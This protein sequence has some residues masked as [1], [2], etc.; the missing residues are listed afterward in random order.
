[1]IRALTAGSG[2]RVKGD[3]SR[4]NA[5]CGGRRSRGVLIYSQRCAVMSGPSRL[6]T[7]CSW[8]CAAD[9]KFGSSSSSMSLSLSFQKKSHKPP[10]YS[11]SVMKHPMRWVLAKPVVTTGLPSTSRSVHIRPGDLACKAT[12]VGWSCGNKRPAHSVELGVGPLMG[13]NFLSQSTQFFGGVI[14]GGALDELR[15]ITWPMQMMR[16]SP[17]Q[18]SMQAGKFAF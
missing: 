13:T 3:A 11:T 10:V 14:E 4:I 17:S 2:I 8:L 12:T 15:V 9:L 18:A 16:E 1:M 5:F 7:G 6:F